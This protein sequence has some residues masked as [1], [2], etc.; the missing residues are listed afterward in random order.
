MT[1]GQRRK[2]SDSECIH[3]LSDQKNELDEIEF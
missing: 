1:G 2:E 3:P